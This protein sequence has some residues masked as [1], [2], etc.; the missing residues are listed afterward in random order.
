MEELKTTL[1]PS[2]PA[3]APLNR[4]EKF[5]ELRTTQGVADLEK[6]LTDLKAQEETI[7]ATLRQRT[8]A[9]EGKPV[10]VGVISGRKSEIQK[11]EQENLDLVQRQKARVV[12]ELN[13][14]YSVINTYM[15]LMGLDYQDAVSAYDKE[16]ERNFSMYGIILDQQKLQTD[17]WY[18]DQAIA[19]T[20][21]QIYMNAV[22]AGN[23]SYSSLSSDQKLTISKLEAQSGMPIGFISNLQI[24]PKDKILAFSDDKTQAIII[25]DDGE[26]KVISTGLSKSQ[27]GSDKSFSAA[28]AD[29]KAGMT[30]KD[31][32]N[33]YGGVVDDYQLI[34]AYNSNSPHGPMTEPPETFRQWAGT[35]KATAID[36]EA[37]DA[38]A[39]MVVSEQITISSV[40]A[41]Y[42]SEVSKKVEELEKSESSGTGIWDRIKSTLGF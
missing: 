15:N 26:M 14:K 38:Y 11:Q 28:I 21:L 37:V 4:V 32:A 29:A 13:T 36:Q 40:P 9:E 22:T 7:N 23:L 33:K 35:N 30:S 24:A 6:T 8:A 12:D 39:N 1:A 27:T 16:F 31:I 20:N 17:Q 3:P 2:T 41:E 5:E 25:G 42:R 10:P 18:K 34:N 19:T